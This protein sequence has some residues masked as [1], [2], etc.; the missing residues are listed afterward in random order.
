M[1]GP[2]AD[3]SLLEKAGRAAWVLDPDGDLRPAVPLALGREAPLRVAF[4]DGAGG[5]G[6]ERAI[7]ANPGRW[8]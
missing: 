3:G 8:G 6:L 1:T 5:G 2:A 4:Q 7:E